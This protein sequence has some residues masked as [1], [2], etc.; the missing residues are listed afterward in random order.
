MNTVV[1]TMK[2][3]KKMKTELCDI[4][5]TKRNKNAYHFFVKEMAAKL[6]ERIDAG[7][8]SKVD[9]SKTSK[10]YS[11]AWKELEDK[12]KYQQLAEE[13]AKRVEEIRVRHDSKTLPKRPSTPYQFFIRKMA[14][15][16]KEKVSDGRMEKVDFKDTSQM[17]SNAWKELEDKSEW[18][19]MARQDKERYIHEM[20][21][22]GLRHMKR[23]RLNVKPRPQPPFLLFFKERL[24]EVRSSTGMSYSECQIKLG[25]MWK[26]ELSEEDKEVYRRKSEESFVQAI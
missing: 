21:A 7:E 13:D 17:Y 9:F 23:K 20:K 11:S 5:K 1:A 8:I 18:L 6:K 2:R 3:N 16:I 4:M 14:A 26:N 12:S 25:S 22:L 19:E 10:L 15:D 24:P